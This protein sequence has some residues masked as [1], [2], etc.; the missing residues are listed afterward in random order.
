MIQSVIIRYHLADQFHN[1]SSADDIN[2]DDLGIVVKS[3]YYNAEELQ[4]L[5]TTY[6]NKE[7]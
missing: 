3:K 5:K 1:M 6:K 4:N 7:L 2:T